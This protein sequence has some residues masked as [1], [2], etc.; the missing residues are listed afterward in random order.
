MTRALGR[1]EGDGRA[2]KR[3][4]TSTLQVLQLHAVDGGVVLAVI[5]HGDVDTL[6]FA[7]ERARRAG[8]LL[9]LARAVQ[10]IAGWSAIARMIA[11][12][13]RTRE[14]RTARRAGSRAPISRGQPRTPA[15]RACALCGVPQTRQ[16]AAP[17]PANR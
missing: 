8:N 2:V 7:V 3:T 17:S 5:V 14:A 10:V 12:K 16:H 13:R 9:E 4:E 15:S 11:D 6:G 1:R